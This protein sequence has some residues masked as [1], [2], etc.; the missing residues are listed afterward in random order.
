MY[1]IYLKD[2]KN[3]SVHL[4]Q[5]NILEKVKRIS[6]EQFIKY[7]TGIPISFVSKGSKPKEM[8]FIAL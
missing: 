6:S 5:L 7:F 4:I 1:S 2:L 3:K 8:K